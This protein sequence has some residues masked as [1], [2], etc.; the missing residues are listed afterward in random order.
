MLGDLGGHLGLSEA[1]LEPS[2]AILGTLRRRPNTVLAPCGSVLGPSWARS[3][4]PS[5]PKKKNLEIPWFFNVFV[6]LY[7]FAFLTN[8]DAS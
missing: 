2:L 8:F 3:D 1:L 5:L 4:L 7:I 6:H